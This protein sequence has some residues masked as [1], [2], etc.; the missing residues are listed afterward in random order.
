MTIKYP[1]VERNRSVPPMNLTKKIQLTVERHLPGAYNDKGRWVEG[2]RQSLV[3]DANVQPA[4]GYDLL[5]LPESDR[6]E[7]WIK[8]Y[9]VEPLFTLNESAQTDGDIVMWDEVR[10]QVKRTQ[11]YKMGVLDHTKAFAVRLPY[12]NGGVNG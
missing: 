10:Y 9:S 5:V 6:T 7:S 8:I 1:K 12:I 3:I 11:T 2:I 4:K